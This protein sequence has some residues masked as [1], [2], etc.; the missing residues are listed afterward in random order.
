MTPLP[1]SSRLMS[2]AFHDL[3]KERE[4]M[5]A[6]A[7]TSPGWGAMTMTSCL[8]LKNHPMGGNFPVIRTG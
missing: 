8:R 5:S 4:W 6:I 3:A 7:S 1:S 2:A